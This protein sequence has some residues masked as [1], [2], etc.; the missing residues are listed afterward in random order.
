MAATLENGL[1][2]PQTGKHWVTVWPAILFLGIY[3]G[4]MK[5]YIHTKTCT[6]IFITVSFIV[7]KDKW[8]VAYPYN[9]ML[10]DHEKEWKKK[11]NE[12]LI[13]ATTR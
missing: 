7:A 5:A 3:P 2:A 13:D 4:G 9:G 11:K 1:S 6:W 10:F 12:A 8:N